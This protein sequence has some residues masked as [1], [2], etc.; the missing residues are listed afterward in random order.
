MP[1]ATARAGPRNRQIRIA[2]IMMIVFMNHL[3]RLGPPDSQIGSG[4]DRPKRLVP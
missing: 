1:V 3:N 4:A 2:N